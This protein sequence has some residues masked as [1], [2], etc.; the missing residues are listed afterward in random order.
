M[1]WS[2]KS[3]ASHDQYDYNRAAWFASIAQQRDTGVSSDPCEIALAQVDTTSCPF[4]QQKI[5]QVLEKSLKVV[6]VAD[7]LGMIGTGS[8]INRTQARSWKEERKTWLG[9]SKDKINL[10]INGWNRQGNTS[11]RDLSLALHNFILG[12]KR[13]ELQNSKELN[14]QR[15]S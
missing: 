5:F 13:L 2:A 4:Q 1:R 3:R 11:P 9:S 10:M 12:Q 14:Y 7:V 15:N 8:C 6:C